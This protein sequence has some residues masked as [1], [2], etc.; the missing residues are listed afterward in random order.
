LGGV[1]GDKSNQNIRCRNFL[2]IKTKTKQN[3][4]KLIPRKLRPNTG[5]FVDQAFS[6]T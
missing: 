5:D 4:K 2:K 1:E 3:T 6:V